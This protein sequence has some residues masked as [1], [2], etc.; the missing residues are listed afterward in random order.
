MPLSGFYRLKNSLKARAK[1]LG[2]KLSDKV[3]YDVDEYFRR[4]DEM[5]KK[6]KR[7]EAL[8]K[9]GIKSK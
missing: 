7:D 1:R 9:H 6:A 8:A 3:F 4:Q 5:N 2:K